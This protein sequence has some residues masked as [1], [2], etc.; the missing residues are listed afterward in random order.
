MK[1]CLYF[2]FIFFAFLYAGCV[3]SIE[4][5]QNS[6]LHTPEHVE[7]GDTCGKSGYLTSKT[8]NI[9]GIELVRIPDRKKYKG[10]YFGKYEITQAQWCAVIGNNPSHFLGDMSRPV[11]NVTWEDAKEFIQKLNNI[12][13]V[14]DT[15]FVFRLPTQSEWEYA[16]L[17]RSKGGYGLLANGKEG[18]L[19]EMAWSKD[20]SENMT[21]PVGLKKPNAWGLYDMHGSV[22]EWTDTSSQEWDRLVCGGSYKFGE[23]VC[24]GD[25]WLRFLPVY[26][27][28]DVGFRIVAIKVEH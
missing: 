19:E 5:Q 8:I 26:K 9:F 2:I 14:K 25:F 23:Y 1:N 28:E 7:G 4:N 24:R 21:H 18:T 16:C 6:V 17:A 20:N 10:L 27:S 3:C 13:E 15:G 22:W 11:E 12:P